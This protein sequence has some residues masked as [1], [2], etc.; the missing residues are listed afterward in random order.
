LRLKGPDVTSSE[1]LLAFL[2]SPFVLWFLG[3]VVIGGLTAGATY[4]QKRNAEAMQRTELQRRLS[5]E[6]QFRI[7]SGQL[8]LR[9]TRQ[10]V[11]SGETFTPFDVYNLPVLYL[12]NRVGQV[13]FSIFPEYRERRFRSLLFELMH[14]VPKAQLPDLKA[15]DSGYKELELEAD[16][17]GIAPAGRQAAP[18][19]RADMLGIVDKTASRVDRLQEQVGRS[20]PTYS[21]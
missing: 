17:A 13:D 15:A 12:N 10:R 18:A 6:L 19:A 21:N 11:D 7:E 14:V 3:S 4:Y 8:A 9:L 20:Q 16:N 2:N 1:R 5:T